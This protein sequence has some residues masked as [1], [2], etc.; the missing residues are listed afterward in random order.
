MQNPA[1]DKANLNL[2]NESFS[3]LQYVKSPGNNRLDKIVPDCLSTMSKPTR[4]NF[5]FPQKLMFSKRTQYPPP[6]DK[7]RGNLKSIAEEI[8]ESATLNLCEIVDALP[9][10]SLQ[11]S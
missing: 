1:D 3:A 6:Q 5:S 4:Q 2:K 10:D 9:K 11:I 7:E 8:Y